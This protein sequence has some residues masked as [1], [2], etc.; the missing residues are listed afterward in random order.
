M[1]ILLETERYAGHTHTASG[2]ER[3]RA[4]WTPREPE[5]RNVK[6]QCFAQLLMLGHR[7]ANPSSRVP[8]YV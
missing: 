5:P 8:V 4:I 1:Q 3:E 7:D 2:S 6:G